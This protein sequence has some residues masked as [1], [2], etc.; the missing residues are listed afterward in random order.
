VKHE[1]KFTVDM[2]EQEDEQLST[3]SRCEDAREDALK[4]WCS[5]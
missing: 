5:T 1:K 4:A 2:W 3:E